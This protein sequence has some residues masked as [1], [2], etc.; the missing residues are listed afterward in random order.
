MAWGHQSAAT[1]F[2]KIRAGRYRSFKDGDTRLIEWRSVFEDRERCIE[3][4]PQLAP[5]TG[6]LGRP[7]KAQPTPE[8]K[9]KPAPDRK[10]R[11][12]SAPAA[13]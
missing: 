2:R 3:A 8:P 5:R 10:R 11:R 9:S 4:G 13:E 1:V 12:V 6:K 7:K